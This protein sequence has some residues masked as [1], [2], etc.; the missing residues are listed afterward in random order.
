[1]VGSLSFIRIGV[2]L[3]ESDDT[4][5]SLGASN[6]EKVLKRFYREPISSRGFLDCK[7]ETAAIISSLD[8]GTSSLVLISGGAWGI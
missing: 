3:N 6:E 7:E 1:M 5:P 2:C 4:E 8:V